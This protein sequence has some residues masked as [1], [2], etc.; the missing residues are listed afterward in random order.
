MFH[1][2]EWVEKAVMVGAMGAATVG[3][4]YAAIA[5]GGEGN[6]DGM[7][8]GVGA[9]PTAETAFLLASSAPSAFL[10]V[11]TGEALYRDTPKP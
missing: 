6:I 3:G 8:S 4:S 11:A 7:Q 1:D 5:M 9:V 2:K 10:G